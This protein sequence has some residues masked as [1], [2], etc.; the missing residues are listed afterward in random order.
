MYIQ[1]LLNVSILLYYFTTNSTTI[2]S[3]NKINF[4]ISDLIMTSSEE[5]FN[6][7]QRCNP[8]Y[9]RPD[10]CRTDIMTLLQQ[11]PTFKLDSEKKSENVYLKLEGI[12]PILKKLDS[13]DLSLNVIID[14]NHPIKPPIFI[15]NENQFF[16]R[17][18]IDIIDESGYI[19]L[20]ML[21]NW[22]KNNEKLSIVLKEIIRSITMSINRSQK[23]PSLEK[24]KNNDTRNI[25]LLFQKINNTYKLSINKISSNKYI[26]KMVK[27]DYQP[28]SLLESSNI[29]PEEII[30]ISE[31]M[32]KSG[33]KGK[34]ILQMQPAQFSIQ[35]QNMNFAKALLSIAL[36]SNYEESGIKFE[37]KRIIVIIKNSNVNKLILTNDYGKM[38]I[39][40]RYL[41]MNILEAQHIFKT[42]KK[43]LEVLIRYLDK[44]ISNNNLEIRIKSR[45]I[46][47]KIA[48]QKK[49]CPIKVENELIFMNILS[50]PN[51]IIQLIFL[52]LDGQTLHKCRQINKLYNEKIKQLI[53]NDKPAYDKLQTRILY[54]K[55]NAKFTKTSKNVSIPFQ[56]PDIIA[57]SKDSFLVYESLYGYNKFAHYNIQNEE[58]WIIEENREIFNILS[59]FSQNFT[60]IP[61]YIYVNFN[62][63]THYKIIHLY[64]QQDGAASESN[65]RRP[66]IV[67]I[68]S[69]S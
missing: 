15:M 42:E 60:F 8:L 18:E 56:F 55:K 48:I 31:Q 35:C 30:S 43:N 25:L 54:N 36:K 68:F 51:E 19:L 63:F 14:Y 20:P 27:K 66:G 59:N 57:T 67:R 34:L 5:I 41:E 58:L 17:N 38:I 13:F 49:P 10:L 69:F 2:Y 26:I 50:L 22:E 61:I 33:T 40:K 46:E 6:R 9:K 21:K 29:T 12:I 16:S 45:H 24:I 47:K 37:N 1:Y 23:E 28:E 32:E 7:Q 11:F 65:S 4:T 62:L 52:E 53:W 64:T 44:F 3:Q 39:E